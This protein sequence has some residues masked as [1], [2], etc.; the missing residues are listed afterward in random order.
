MHD[1]FISYEH[2]S[3]SIAD[4]IVNVL[5]SSKVRCWYAPRDVIG[6]YAT[7]ICDAIAACKIFVLVLSE[8]SSKSNHC[9]NEV[10]MAYMA[11]MDSDSTNNVIIMPFRVD[12][13]DLNRA[14]EYY[15]KRLHWID[16]TNKSLDNA[17]LEL[18]EKITCILGID[19]KKQSAQEKAHERIENKYDATADYELERLKTQLL[20]SKQFDQE[21]YDKA[22]SGKSGL[23][24]LDVGCNT[25]DHVMD[26]LGNKQEVKS[27][28]GLEYMEDAVERANRKF[29]NTKAKFYQCDIE[30][31]DFERILST[32]KDENG[33]EYFDII[34]LSMIILH[35]QNPA[36]LLKRL[37]KQLAVGG[38]IIIKDIDDGLNL[39]YPDE[40]GNFERAFEICSRLETAGYR[41]SGRQIPHYLITNGFKNIQL[42][43]VGV[44]TLNMDY[45]QRQAL[46]DTYFDFVLED[47]GI[48]AKKYPDNLSINEDY[49]WIKQ[50]FSD[51]EDNF[52][53]NGFFFSLG[54]VLFTAEK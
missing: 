6:D 16:A 41:L 28:I 50:S 24:V 7:S 37:R 15:V 8:R 53:E 18:L 32:I 19:L 17:I 27:I 26:R 39:A 51:L 52:Q 43:T 2:E 5:E 34:N 44:N 12:D 1:V 35:L 38:K 40:E 4:N 30:G 14:M 36:K 47:C 23:N 48:M 46:F 20:I 3:K 33:I 42:E 9:L 31:V 29:A 54:F 10:E 45:D 49:K 25:G 11:N 21:F 13:K 22:V